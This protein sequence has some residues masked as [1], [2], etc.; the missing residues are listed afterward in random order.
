MEPSL[1]N[2]I[3]NKN[4]ENSGHVQKRVR[5]SNA[6][7]ICRERKVRCDGQ[8]PVCGNCAKRDTKCIYS[9]KNQKSRATI[10][11]VRDLEERVR[12]YES[13]EKRSDGSQSSNNGYGQVTQ[14]NSHKFVYEDQKRFPAI[15]PGSAAAQGSG[16]ILNN[17]T[18]PS[19]ATGFYQHQNTNTLPVIQY[20]MQQDK[21]NVPH[22]S[23]T[24]SDQQSLGPDSS[25]HKGIDVRDNQRTSDMSLQ[26]IVKAAASSSS[27]NATSY[28]STIYD[29]IRDI[30]SESSQLRQMHD[31]K[32]VGSLENFEK[33]AVFAMP[34]VLGN[35]Q[36]SPSIS[37]LDRTVVDRMVDLYLTNIHILMPM[38]HEPTFRKDM[39]SIWDVQ[40]NL[41][42][43]DPCFEALAW[44]VCTLG[45]LNMPDGENEKFDAKFF[46]ELALS[47]LNF[48]VL[49]TKSITN[50]QM[51]VLMIISSMHTA[52]IET[53]LYLFD[54]CVRCCQAMG[55]D[56]PHTYASLSSLIDKE[57]A[58]RCWHM[59]NHMDRLIAMTYMK[60]LSISRN[61][62]ELPRALDDEYITANQY[63]L[64]PLNARPSYV[65]YY[66]HSIKLFDII[67]EVLRTFHF[68]EGFNAHSPTKSISDILNI[69]HK[70]QVYRRKLPEYLRLENYERKEAAAAFSHAERVQCNVLQSRY[71]HTRIILLRH[72]LLGRLFRTS[73]YEETKAVESNWNTVYTRSY[74]GYLQENTEL[75]ICNLCIIT[76]LQLI[77]L[78]HRDVDQ[79]IPARWACTHHTFLSSLII[80]NF[81]L[82]PSL[83]AMLDGRSVEESWKNAISLLSQPRYEKEASKKEVA[84]RCVGVLK[85]LHSRISKYSSK[86]GNILEKLPIIDNM[87][88]NR[89]DSD[90]IRAALYQQ[91]GLRMF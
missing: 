73:A 58:L 71:L 14:E 69:E 5:I 56:K 45:A 78:I 88:F 37:D 19:G 68:G 53:V 61:G 43:K 65:T 39:E 70:L 15:S 25:V 11:Y 32:P 9:N 29:E 38:V 40:G 80:F 7:Q 21:Q 46:F 60:S 51:L 47:K 26:N 27:S 31:G 89:E 6:C 62:V 59:L 13:N 74:E 81:A 54:A 66:L 84:L 67:E 16:Q 1:V 86:N 41:D 12:Y 90:T 24:F 4:I 64:P 8:M 48:E 10:D 83:R 22:Y 17:I 23:S 3:D 20:N 72:V 75:S 77:Q 18:P 33:M 36:S 91:L 44:A 57:C 82:Q 87:N 52:Q 35:S 34:V 42:I 63:L 30:T 55:L 76:A 79:V 2:L 28:T 49:T 50:V 85:S